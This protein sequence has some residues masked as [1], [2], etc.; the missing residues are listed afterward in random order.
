M[1]SSLNITIFLNRAIKML[2]RKAQKPSE[3]R[4][5]QVSELFNKL[6]PHSSLNM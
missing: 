3:Q 4:E 1:Q 5:I 6:V 2:T